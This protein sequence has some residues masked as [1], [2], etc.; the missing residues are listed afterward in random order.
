MIF[1]IAVIA[2]VTIHLDERHESSLLAYS[3]MALSIVIAAGL[4]LLSVV[5]TNSISALFVCENRNGLKNLE[6]LYVTG[7]LQS[8]LEKHFTSLLRTD[9]PEVTV[10]IKNI[11]WELSDY[12]RCAT[13][14]SI[15]PR[16]EFFASDK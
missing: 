1:C 6:H 2:E 5:L 4:T 11:V 15:L 10:H 16:C 7:D 12:L 14:L 8:M 3:K 9:D 13:Y